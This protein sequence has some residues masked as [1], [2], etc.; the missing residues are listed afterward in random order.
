MESLVPHPK[1]LELTLRQRKLL[2]MMQHRTSFITGAE[3]ARELGVTSRTIR[4]DILEINQ[5]ISPYQAEICSERSKGYR[6]AARDPELIRSLNQIGLG[7]MTRTDRVRYLAFRL[8]LS[9]VPLN[10]F[11]LEDEMFISHTT[12]EQDLQNLRTRFCQ[13]EPYLELRWQ[14]NE[15][16]FS[17]D[18][19]K[20]RELLTCL[21]HEDWDYS[22][23]GNAYYDYHFLDEEILDFV[24]E[25]MPG[26]LRRNNLLMDDPH[27]V[28]LEIAVTVADQRFRS[29]HMLP[30]IGEQT[31]LSSACEE[32]FTLLETR[33]QCVFPENEKQMIDKLFSLGRPADRDPTDIF[34]F[35]ESVDEASKVLADRYLDRLREAFGIDFQG[36]RDFYVTLCLY[37]QNLKK[38]PRVYS[39]QENVSFTK[40][41]LLDEFEMATLFQ[42]LAGEQ[43]GRLLSEIELINLAHCISGALEFFFRMHPEYKL[44]TVICGHRDMISLWS[45]KRDVLGAFSNYLDITH[46]MPLNTAADFDFSQTDLA[47]VTAKREFLNDR[48]PTVLPI[49]YI[50]TEEDRSRISEYINAQRMERAAPAASRTDA[51]LKTIRWHE[52]ASYQTREE[53]LD[54][55]LKDFSD[56]MDWTARFRE[57]LMQ[58]EETTSFVTGPGIVFLH[59]LLPAPETRLSIMTMD[60]RVIWNGSKIRIFVLGSF[61]KGDLP[62]LLRLKHLFSA[63][64]REDLRVMKT[65]AAV[66]DYFH[67]PV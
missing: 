46:L 64:N 9:E 67:I 10:L 61:T 42:E 60:H 51:L 21:V 34:C 44:K 48:L 13:G 14:R 49:H 43:L 30:D 66:I 2:H 57:D 19:Q 54:A 5:A 26:I 3:L 50:L 17:A 58:R 36:D 37:I 16:C 23:K 47:L 59:S 25:Q 62:V 39:N 38:N 7:L 32:L 33:N 28:Y 8:C 41:L 12:L 65:K 55:L 15:V 1:K 20:H 18:E 45:A 22:N 6:F 63:C 4:S 29:G 56:D 40:D 53:V 31:A 35:S 52:K 11:D 27:L 24:M